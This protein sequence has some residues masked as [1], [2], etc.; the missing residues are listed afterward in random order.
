[1]DIKKRGVIKEVE[2]VWGKEYWIVNNDRYCGKELHL[3]EG[4]QS[5]LHYHKDKDETFYIIKGSMFLEVENNS[6]W[7]LILLGKGDIID[8][9][10][11]VKHR[12]S[13][14]DDDCIFIEFSSHHDDNDTYREELSGKIRDVPTISEEDFKDIKRSI[15]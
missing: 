1:M 11:G 12:F 2:K 8:I 5:S 14:F 4:Y 10:K 7:E 6:T 3:K 13:T 15:G 9:P